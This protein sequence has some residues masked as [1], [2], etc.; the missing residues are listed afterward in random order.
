MNYRV[1]AT[2][3]LV[4]LSMRTGAAQR[5]T[6]SASPAPT[7]VMIHGR[8]Q[9]SRRGAAVEGAWN[10][11][12]DV[13]LSGI[14]VALLVPPS[15]RRFY[16]YA[17]TLEREKG[18]A[19]AFGEGAGWRAQDWAFWPEA[20]K[21]L[22]AAAGQLPSAAQQAL[23]NSQMED[24][25]KYLSNGS[26]ACA[27]DGGL[28][29]LWD[30]LPAGAPVIVVAHSMGSMVLYKNLMGSLARSTQPTYIIT[31]GSMI[32]V[33]AVQRTLLGSN[34]GYPAPVPLPVV[35]WRNIVNKGDFLAFDAR[36]SFRSE[37]LAKIPI[38]LLLD[39]VGDD[40]HAATAYLASTTFGST[41]R[42]AWCLA[43]RLPATCS[44]S[45]SDTGRG[46]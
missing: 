6:P 31:I 36:T 42:E 20:R 10:H 8:D 32:A 12:I 26:V 37:T 40:R 7:V 22:V 15:S 17:D 4:C 46:R 33:P 21:V 19:F 45:S 9:Q 16:W 5:R 2:V 41:L 27:V 3:C 35:W 38:D 18:C 14:K 25:A 24:T 11:A 43:S 34:A 23:L 30:E 29:A 13:G 1:I 44:P 39:T 28:A